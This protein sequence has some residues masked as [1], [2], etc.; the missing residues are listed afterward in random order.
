MARASSGRKSENIT[1]GNNRC[2]AL[3]PLYKL[4]GKGKKADLVTISSTFMSI[5]LSHSTYLI[6]LFV[7]CFE[8]I[9]R[10]IERLKFETKMLDED[11]NATSLG[12]RFNSH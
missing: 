10:I 6:Q 8:L 7:H 2:Q 5:V 11:P 4:G 1:P 12:G 9:A 3:Y